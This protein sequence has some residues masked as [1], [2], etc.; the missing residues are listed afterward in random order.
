[1]GDRGVILDEKDMAEEINKHL[2]K[3]GRDKIGC[4][5]EA[6]LYYSG[7]DCGNT[8]FSHPVPADDIV[9]IIDGLKNKISG[10]G[11]L[12]VAMTK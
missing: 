8:Y 4:T 5:A 1:L 2:A 12:P 11:G 9:K 7:E 6:M 3:I 10:P